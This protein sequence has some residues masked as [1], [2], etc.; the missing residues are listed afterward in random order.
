[1]KIRKKSRK[2]RRKMRKRQKRAAF[3][4]DDAVYRLTSYG[5][6]RLRQKRSERAGIAADDEE[7]IVEILT[8]VDQEY[9]NQ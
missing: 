6:H 7:G 4:K 2:R 5:E 1:M 3:V 9:V 8:A